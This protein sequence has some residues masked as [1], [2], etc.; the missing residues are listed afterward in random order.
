MAEIKVSP[1]QLKAKAENLRNFNTQFK[2]QV[3]KLVGYE[4]Q[5]AGS[6]EGDAQKE[7]RTAFNTDKAKMDQFYANIEKFVQALLDSAEQYAIAH[8]T[9]MSLAQHRK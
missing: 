1:A 8:Q 9:A 6:W 5:L 4:A 2:Q 3:E 7:F